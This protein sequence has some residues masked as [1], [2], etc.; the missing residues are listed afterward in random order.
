MFKKVFGLLILVAVLVVTGCAADEDI[1]TMNMSP[2]TDATYSIGTPSDQYLNGY[3]VNLWASNNV[4]AT[5]NMTATY[6]VGNGSYL[7]GSWSLG[8]YSNVNILSGGHLYIWD[9]DM[10]DNF[11]LSHD[12]GVGII[13]NPT[14]DIYIRGDDHVVA[15]LTGDS[16][17][18]FEFQVENS[19]NHEVFSV[20]TLGNLDTEG[21]IANAN[22]SI[23]ADGTIV[24]VSMADASALNNSIY[25]STT[26]SKLVYKDS[27]GT[28]HDLY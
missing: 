13:E 7:T 21:Y 22:M 12:G 19:N 17:G 11:H 24:P 6:F 10:S 14:G 9:S 28:V 8:N 20:D 25:Y 4:T 2:V 27:T 5:N 26:Q 23:R 1:T 3:F 16:A 15:D 18:V